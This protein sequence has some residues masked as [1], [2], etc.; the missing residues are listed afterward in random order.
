MAAVVKGRGLREVMGDVARLERE[1]GMRGLAYRASYE[2]S[3]ALAPPEPPPLPPPPVFRNHSHVFYVAENDFYNPTG[4]ELKANR[5]VVDRFGDRPAAVKTATWFVPWF[6]HVL[7]GGIHT[8]LRFVSWMQTEHG[9]ES[10]IVIY[11]HPDLNDSDVRGP[12]ASVFPELGSIDIVVPPQGRAPY[13]DF[14]EL[15]PTDIAVCTIWYSA[16]ALMRFNAARAKFY[17]VQD[18]EP[19]FYPAGTLWAMAE[20]TYRFGFAGLVNTPG[21]G[22]VYQAY[23][24]PTCAFTP[25]VD[26]LEPETESPDRGGEPVQVVIYGRPSTD[27]NGFELLSAACRRVKARFGPRVRIISAG[28][29]FDPAE[30]ELDGIVENVGLLRT[31]EEIRDLYARSDIGM[32]CMFS[33]HPSYQPF[34]YLASG[35][36]VVTNVNPSISWLL[37][38]G[39]N[40]LLA[41][42]FAEAFADALECLIDD[43]GLRAK[44][45]SSGAHL[46]NSFEWEP[47]FEGLW[48]FITNQDASG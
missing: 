18:F 6:E 44:L 8:I 34:E 27:R 3:R 16:Y 32:Y 39:E 42:P 5:D 25:A 2:V 35:M 9:V 29:D 47:A 21:L 12:I 31:R 20:A 36:T 40:C 17:F 37:R 23:G 26:W 33:R 38:D 4:D 48:R 10:R 30:Y 43:P 41:E 1:R 7:F 22:D 11:D 45:V 24:N 15:P 28:E 19:A 13:V 46:V 14:D